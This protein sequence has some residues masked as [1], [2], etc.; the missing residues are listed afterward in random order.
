MF[1]WHLILLILIYIYT[2]MSRLIH[3]LR[4]CYQAPTVRPFRQQWGREQAIA[5]DQLHFGLLNKNNLVWNWFRVKF[6]CFT[7][8]WD[9]KDMPTRTCLLNVALPPGSWRRIIRSQDHRWQAYWHTRFV[10]GPVELGSTETRWHEINRNSVRLRFA[11]THASTQCPLI[12][13]WLLFSLI[14]ECAWDGVCQCSLPPAVKRITFILRIF[15]VSYYKGTL[16][17]S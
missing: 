15:Y 9:H 11:I 8:N 10:F 12:G 17:H 3:M 7:W 2:F 16:R 4:S 5:V 6:Y 13:F 1:A 14:S